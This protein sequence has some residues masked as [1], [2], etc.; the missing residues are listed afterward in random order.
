MPD[1]GQSDPN[2]VDRF[3]KEFKKPTWYPFWQQDK[4]SQ[5]LDERIRNAGLSLADKIAVFK[6]LSPSLSPTGDREELRMERLILSISPADLSRFK[7]ALEY[8]GDYKDMVEYV[9]HDI[10]KSEYQKRIIQHFRQGG[11]QIGIKVLSDVDDTMYASLIDARYPKKSPDTHPYPG[12]LEFYDALKREPFALISIPI[13]A[14]SARP[15]ILNR[16][17]GTLKK[18]VKLSRDRLCPSVLSGEIV[19]SVAGT[20]GT[21][22]RNK[23]GINSLDPAE[24]KIGFVKF[25]N[26]LSFSEVYP[27]YGYVFVGDSGQA[28][29][30]TARLMVAED[31]DLP[32]ERPRAV[33]TFIHDIRE[34]VNDE[35]AVS[36]S[37][38]SLPPEI[39]VSR[40]SKTG[41]GVIVFRN[42]IEAALIAHIHSE[43][44]GNLITSD[45]LARVTRSA[46]EQFQI[47]FQ[48]KEDSGG[49]LREQYRQDAESSYELL[50]LSQSKSATLEEDVSVIRR[51]LDEGF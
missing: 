10:D 47:V 38:R 33:T 5:K 31:L 12:V 45:G 44:L 25:E 1:I 19:S 8:D 29:A 51:I 48:G 4:R 16:E 9:F 3:F 36:S 37:F 28:D 6:K 41:R 18:L 22:A 27:E 21:L 46:L 14:L 34:T 32:K 35:R 7:F 13:T 15:G 20:I 40:I 17:E 43:T 26:F 39:L 24:D 50:T 11:Q 23:L 2:R 42:Y 30:L 49:N